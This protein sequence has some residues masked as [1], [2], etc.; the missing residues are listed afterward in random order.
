MRKQP[1]GAE[2]IWAALTDDDLREQ[3]LD[4]MTLLD[5]RGVVSGPP[6]LVRSYQ[7]AAPD[8]VIPG[9]EFDLARFTYTPGDVATLL[10]EG[11]A[12]LDEITDQYNDPRMDDSRF[13]A[14]CE[15]AAN[16]H[17][18]G[19]LRMRRRHSSTSTGD[20]PTQPIL[21]PGLPPPSRVS[22]RTPDHGGSGLVTALLTHSAPRHVSVVSECTIS[23]RPRAGASVV[24]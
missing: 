15:L 16:L 12:V 13:D 14:Y 19:L 23:Y 11:F 2:P 7:R 1:R 17:R 24:G 3:T 8:R 21:L 4:A 9:I 18:A 5:I 6:E 22:R 10:D 20:R